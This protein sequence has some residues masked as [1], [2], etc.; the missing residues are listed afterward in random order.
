[1]TDA[2]NG[3]GTPVAGAPQE[4]KF[5]IRILGQYVKDLSFESPNIRK[6]MAGPADNPNLNLE[7]NVRPEQVGPDVFETTL[8]F[9]ARA[10]SKSIGV[11]F[12][13]EVDYSGL[14]KIENAPR[15]VL[16]PILHVQCPTLLFPFVRRI[17]A[18][19]TRDGG[20][21]PP[22]MLDPVDFGALYM[23]K[24]QSMAMAGPAT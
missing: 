7:I 21:M 16:D 15:E 2:A 5:Q 6:L 11:I 24:R 9:K 14:F 19:M 3:N 18:D 13:M 10:E 17:V 22:L 4:P 8:S 23:R 20:I 12:E 1:M